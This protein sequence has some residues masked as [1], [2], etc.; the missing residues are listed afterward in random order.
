MPKQ[1][2][3]PVIDLSSSDVPEV[4][5]KLGDALSEF[6]FAV[7]TNHGIGKDVLAEAYRVTRKTFALPQRTKRRY[8]CAEDGRF[9]GFCSFGIERAV[10][11][12]TEDLKE[13]WHYRIS[14]SE[15]RMRV[16]KEVPEFSRT[17]RDLYDRLEKVSARLLGHLDDY[18]LQPHGTLGRMTVGGDSLLRLLYYPKLKGNEKGVRSAAHE[19][20]NL[21][22]LLVSA[23]TSG[24]EAQ[25]RA[26]EWIPV[27]N[28][29]DAIVVNAGDMLQMYTGG[30]IPSTTHRVVN[31]SGKVRY[32]IPFFVHPRRDVVLSRN[33][34]IT[35]GDYLQQRLREIGLKK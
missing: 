11:A 1:A 33:P 16:P 25:T 23:T 29:P 7:V 12:P 35:A 15:D 26:G 8:E 18:L 34:V 27:N 30:R 24:L 14:V 32:S 4:T 31:G 2:E 13:F 28:P 10:N 3:I 17:M 22:T 19:D 5:Q 9:T 20:I 21:I 6:G